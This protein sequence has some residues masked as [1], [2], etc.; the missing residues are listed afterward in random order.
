[1]L[2]QHVVEFPGLPYFWGISLNPT[3]FLFLTF[4]S[5]ESS[6]SCV[7]CPSLIS[8]CLL[9][10]PVIGLC[11]TFG[12]FPNKFP[13]CCFHCCIRSSGRFQFSF[14]WALPSAYFIYRLPCYPRLSIFTE[15]LILLIWF[16]MCSVCSFRY[17]LANSFCAFLS[18][19]AL[20]LVGF[21][22]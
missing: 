1:M 15:S 9:I 11:V 10:I 19:T 3:A 5:A 4:L 2:K 16:C 18:F 7:N 14:R 6:S 8:N 21:F 22:L 13:K 12:G 20:I 17:M